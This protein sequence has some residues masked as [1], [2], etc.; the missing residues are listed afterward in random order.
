MYS[1]VHVTQVTAGQKKSILIWLLNRMKEE[2]EEELVKCLV[3]E[4]EWE[5]GRG[6]KSSALATLSQ[7][8]GYFSY[9]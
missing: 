9:T 6:S 3:A 2:D 1:Q 7:L 4:Q 8:S 5:P